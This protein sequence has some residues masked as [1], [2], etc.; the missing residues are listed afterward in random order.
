MGVVELEEAWFDNWKRK[1]KHKKQYSGVLT[2]RKKKK[3]EKKGKKAPTTEINPRGA[4]SG[5]MKERE[6][7]R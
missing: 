1:K 7:T 2:K 3:K 4:C 5:K 6:A